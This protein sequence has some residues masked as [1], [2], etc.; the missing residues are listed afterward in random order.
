MFVLIDFKFS[1]DRN[2]N[3]SPELKNVGES[4]YEN[5]RYVIC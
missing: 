3:S 4:N 2:K 5:T 1:K